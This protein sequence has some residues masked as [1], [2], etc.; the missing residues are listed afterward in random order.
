MSATHYHQ[1]DADIDR[2]WVWLPIAIDPATI[3]AMGL[4]PQS[5]CF[6]CETV[7]AML[8]DGSAQASNAS[9][10][11]SAPKTSLDALSID[12]QLAA[13][14]KHVKANRT[15]VANDATAPIVKPKL[16]L[17]FVRDTGIHTCHAIGCTARVPPRLLMC[18]THWKRVPK[19][20]QQRILATYVPGQE[21]RKDPTDAYMEA[22]RAAVQAVAEKEGKL[23]GTSAKRKRGASH[24]NQLALIDVDETEET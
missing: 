21:Q 9:G 7:N 18:A 2:P 24:P 22:Q 8:G 17:A 10:S 12:D 11:A 1:C 14:A 6:V 16:S 5:P 19:E 13:F 23:T 20:L 4:S 15:T 3:D